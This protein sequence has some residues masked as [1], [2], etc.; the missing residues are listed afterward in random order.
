MGLKG[1]VSLVNLWTLISL[2]SR[3][4]ICL[5]HMLLQALSRTQKKLL[6]QIS[7]DQ[8]RSANTFCHNRCQPMVT[9]LGIKDSATHMVITSKVDPSAPTAYNQVS[10]WT[11]SMDTTIK[12]LT[13]QMVKA[14]SS[15]IHLV[16]YH[17]INMFVVIQW[18]QARSRILIQISS[19]IR[20]HIIKPLPLTCN[21]VLKC[22]YHL[23]RLS[24]SNPIMIWP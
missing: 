12:V 11:H 6:N 21:M 19:H 22:L 7:N 15:K 5:L 13:W 14:S 3:E 1:L 10:S 18:V 9:W 24:K 2:T 23:E 16:N 17:L 4:K 8:K 20:C